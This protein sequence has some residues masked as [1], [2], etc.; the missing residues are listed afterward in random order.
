LVTQALHFLPQVDHIIVVNDGTV[1]EQGS[2][3]QLYRQNGQLRKMVDYRET[4]EK[5]DKN[6]ATDKSTPAKKEEKVEEEAL[7]GFLLPK[8]M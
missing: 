3:A 2:Y 8:K 6:V 5:T 7:L 4:V 1:A